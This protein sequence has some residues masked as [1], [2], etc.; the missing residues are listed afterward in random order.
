MHSIAPMS[1]GFRSMEQGRYAQA[2]EE[3]SRALK[4]KPKSRDARS[5]LDQ[6]QQRITAEKINGLLK[7]AE[8]AEQ[9]ENWQGAVSAYEAALK[10][11]KNLG[12]AQEGKRR[13]A[14]RGEIHDK[15]EQILA[16]PER[17]FDQNAFNEVVGFR[18]KIQALSETGPVLAGQ[19]ARLDRL[20]KLADKPVTVQ[21]RS[22]NLTLVTLYKV[23]E[24]GYFTSKSLSLRPGHYVAVGQRDGYRDVRVEFFVD[25]DQ[26][27]E[28]VIVSSNEKIALGN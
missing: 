27:M 19:I 23:G 22:D 13:A 28:P 14:L 9:N 16:G 21:L 20:L 25:P 12:N 15:L 7:Q 4:I 18:D 10:L 11:D 1:S 8:T 17:L 5:G 3:F 24:L 26:A 6:A 2:Q